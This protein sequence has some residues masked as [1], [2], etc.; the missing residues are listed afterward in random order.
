MAARL[1][2]FGG[3]GLAMLLGL[4]AVVGLLAG[5]EPK[6]A[7]LA[8]AACG[9]VLLVFVNLA[10]GLAIFTAEPIGLSVQESGLAILVAIL[11]VLAWVAV[12]VVRD[13]AKNDFLAAH[14]GMSAI[15]G[16][17]LGWTALSLA[18]AE[19]PSEA[20]GTVG[21]Y[22]VAVALFLIVFTAVRTRRHATMLAG[23]FL[24]GA[25]IAAA[26]ALISVESTEA[27]FGGRLA[28]ASFDPNELAATLVAG[29]ALSFGV[30]P[31]L[32]SSP[33]L[34]VL[35]YAAGA[36]CFVAIFPTVS[37]GGLIAL[38][39]MLVAA[40]VFSGRWRFR[41][42]LVAVTIAVGGVFYIA[43]LAPA[44][45]RERI[46]QTSRGQT[47]FLEGR[48]TIWEVAWRMVDANIVRGVGA[49]NFKISSRHYLLRPGSV[50]RSDEI[51]DTPKV[52]HSSYL[53]V[54]TGLGVVGLALFVAIVVFALGA[55]WQ[56]ARLF[57]IGN[58]VAGEAVARA[59]VIALIGVLTANLFMSQEANKQLW[60]LLGLGP[61]LYSVARLSLRQPKG[62]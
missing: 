4:A 12:V 23:A 50:T 19:S 7:I 20:L 32:R 49:G 62:T 57:Q 34:R 10:A 22:A 6:L 15:L 5:L 42:T 31:A 61:A 47:K 56:A 17:F 41:V 36:F 18:W 28:S 8:A 11:L 33:G 59:L 55:A 35:A 48:T 21:R 43:A 51:I 37:R 1:E 24:A 16:L 52:A 44:E 2:L 13:E 30:A 29:M 3:L 25:V 9:F 14:P 45:D 26:Y 46:E 54:L 40:I 58:D 53:E 27:T 39:M 60:L 38:G